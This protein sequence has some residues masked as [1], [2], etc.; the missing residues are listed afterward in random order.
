MFVTHT[1]PKSNGSSSMLPA[2]SVGGNGTVVPQGSE[3]Y[4]A[5]FSFQ[6]ATY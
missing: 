5:Q 1:T 3:G 2:A 4:W 6:E